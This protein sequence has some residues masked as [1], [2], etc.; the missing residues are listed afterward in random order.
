MSAGLTALLSFFLAYLLGAGVPQL[1]WKKYSKR[2][3]P[4]YGRIKATYIRGAS[5][6]VFVVAITA[7]IALSESGHPHR[8]VT[9]IVWYGVAGLA[10]AILVGATFWIEPEKSEESGG[11]ARAKLPRGSN[12]TVERLEINAR[13]VSPG[14]AKPPPLLPGERQRISND[15]ATAGGQQAN[16]AMLRK[17]DRGTERATEPSSPRPHE[18]LARTMAAGVVARKTL[19]EDLSRELTA[20][21]RLLDPIDMPKYAVAHGEAEKIQKG[22][23]ERWARDWARGLRVRLNDDPGMVKRFDRGADLPHETHTAAFG[24]GGTASHEQ[25][26][27]FLQDKVANLEDIIQGLSP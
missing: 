27:E 23:T 19:A 3:R 6:T 11:E 17:I 8:P 7:G 20:G 14:P 16:D 24:L 13:R 5:G 18:Q 15:F 4:S 1:L 22:A 21:R 25:L 12:P 9:Y 10:L 26:V 2:V